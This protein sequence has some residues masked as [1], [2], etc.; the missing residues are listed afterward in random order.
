[1]VVAGIAAISEL[2]LQLW[3]LVAGVNSERWREQAEAARV[4]R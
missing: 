3:L 1:L 4:R 2:P